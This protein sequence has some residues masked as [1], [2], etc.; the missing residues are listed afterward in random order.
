MFAAD[1]GMFAHAQIIQGL[2]N[3]GINAGRGATTATTDHT[4]ATDRRR[5]TARVRTVGGF[6]VADSWRRISARP[7]WTGP[8]ALPHSPVRLPVRGALLA[9]A[10]LGLRVGLESGDGRGSVGES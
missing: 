3:A 2:E 1:V 9:G 7:A 10:G 5:L 8:A 4:F 6:S